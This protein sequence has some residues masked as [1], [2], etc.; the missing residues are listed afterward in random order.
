MAVSV[1]SRCLQG[2]DKV[3]APSA[4]ALPAGAW[5]RRSRPRALFWGNAAQASA[6]LAPIP[7]VA[8]DSDYQSAFIPLDTDKGGYAAGNLPVTLELVAC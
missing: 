6:A 3:S 5:A 7:T 4:W 1:G 8:I 2:I